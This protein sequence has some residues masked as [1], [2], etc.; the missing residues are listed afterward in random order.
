MLIVCA[1]LHA[2]ISSLSDRIANEKNFYRVMEMAKLY[3]DSIDQ[4]LR[5]KHPLDMKRKHWERYKYRTSTLLNP[6]GTIANYV[7]AFLEADAYVSKHMKEASRETNSAWTFVGPSAHVATPTTTNLIGKGRVD[8]IA[9]HPSNANIILVGTPDGGMWKTINGGTSWYSVNDNLPAMGISGIEFCASNPSIVYALTG[10]GDGMGVDQSAGVLKSLDGGETWQLTNTVMSEIFTGFNI[11]VH[12]TNANICFIA[13]N[14][15]LYRTFNGGQHWVSV[16]SDFTYDVKFKP[17][18]PSTVYSV[19]QSSFKKW[20]DNGTS[21]TL[22]NTILLPTGRKG[23]GVTAANASYVYVLS[24]PMTGP[25]SFA[26]FWQSIDSGTSLVIK[27]TTPNVFGGEGGGGSDQTTYDFAIAT[28]A[29]NADEIYAAGLIVFKS[30]NNGLNW[31]NATTYGANSSSPS[32]VHPDIHDVKINPINGFVYVAGDGG[33]YKSTDGGATWSNITNNINTTQIYHLAVHPSNHLYTVIGCQ[34]NGTKLKTTETT[35]MDHVAGADGFCPAYSATDPSV[36]FSSTN[37]AFDK[38]TNNGTVLQNISPKSAWFMKAATHVSNGNIVFAGSDQ[39]HIST[40]QGPPWT[41]YNFPANQAITTCPSLA[42]RLYISGNDG[43]NK[44]HRVD[45]LGGNFTR[46]DTNPGLTNYVG[47]TDI[48][49]HPILEDYVYV[50]YHGFDRGNKVFFSDDAGVTWTNISFNLPNIPILCIQV[51]NNNDVFVGT[52]IGVFYKDNLGSEWRPFS[53]QLP[54]VRVS[55]MVYNQASNFL[56]VGTFGRGIWRTQAANG[57][58]TANVTSLPSVMKGYQFY[59]ASNSITTSSDIVGSYGTDVHIKAANYIDLVDGF[60]IKDE[61]TLGRFYLGECGLGL[62]ATSGA[63]YAAMYEQQTSTM[64]APQTDDHYGYRSALEGDYAAVSSID[65]F[66]TGGYGKGAVT[67]LKYNGSQWSLAS[68]IQNSGGAAGDNFGYD[69][70]ISNTRVAISA[71]Y[72]NYSG[73]TDA[74]D[75]D[76]YSLVG[77]SW[78]LE[79]KVLDPLPTNNGL[80]GKSI[81]LN[82]DYLVVG[83]PDKSVGSNVGQGKAYVFK[84]S[85]ATWPLLAEITASDGNAFDGFGYSVDLNGTTIAI[86]SPLSNGTGKV[87]LYE[88]A[89]SSVLPLASLVASD[90]ISGDRFGHDLHFDADYLGIGAPYHNVNKGAIYLY[91]YNGNV[92]NEH[93]KLFNIASTTTEF[94]GSIFDLSSST[95]IVGIPSAS[96]SKGLVYEYGRFGNLWQKKNT[97]TSSDGAANHQFGKSVAIDKTRLVVGAIGANSQQGKAYHFKRD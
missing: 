43:T 64:P 75:V 54:K 8:R 6:D 79:Y 32:Y 9:F 51:T 30:V 7:N 11:A 24:G 26:G 53:N 91:K 61:G 3:Y 35:L 1:S 47:V 38:Y 29:A 76:I 20:S 27:S 28:N 74:G 22:S 93:F 87:Y 48:G 46:L 5:T 69:V 37:S 34:D 63:W 94:F 86:G 40:T 55:D 78:V 77:S 33:F 68:N 95:L 82:G 36:F 56:Y 21:V 72:R 31:T 13:T 50:T 96:S 49:V 52:D 42:T 81:A 67:I 4:G 44:M 14:R 17:S 65:K 89:T 70:S 10:C 97:Y 73:Y 16:T 62:P 57:N 66:L 90:V 25:N 39:L 19:G 60:E 58:C 85:G 59:E 88:I 80:F 45:N 71:P 83:C 12:P 2:Q 92:W 41:N 23:I 18:L 15:G 84:R